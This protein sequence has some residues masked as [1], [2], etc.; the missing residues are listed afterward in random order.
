[1]F[2]R[3]LSF[4]FSYDLDLWAEEMVFHRNKFCQVYDGEFDQTCQKAS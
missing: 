1:M 3:L 2:P 4:A